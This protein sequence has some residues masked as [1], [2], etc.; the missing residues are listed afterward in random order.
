MKT[1]YLVLILF[2]TACGDP[3]KDKTIKGETRGLY[4]LRIV[5][6]EG[7]QYYQFKTYNTYYSICHKGNCNNPQ[8]KIT[9]Q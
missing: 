6:I 2:F 7:C 3:K 8:H 4:G 9:H 5:I 1:F